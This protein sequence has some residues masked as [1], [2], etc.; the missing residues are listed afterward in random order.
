LQRVGP[1]GA[2]CSWF[3]HT[4]SLGE[5]AIGWILAVFANDARADFYDG[6]PEMRTGAPSSSPGQQKSLVGN[7]EASDAALTRRAADGK[8]AGNQETKAQPMR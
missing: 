3:F 2:A 8:P 6:N 1:I 5:L 4:G 7:E